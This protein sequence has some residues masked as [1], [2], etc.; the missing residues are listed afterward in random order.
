MCVRHTGRDKERKRER[1]IERER[2]RERERD[3]ETGM[4]RERARKTKR[5]LDKIGYHERWSFRRLLTFEANY[6]RGGIAEQKG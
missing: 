4:L 5:A 1:E 6:A 3:R 2:E